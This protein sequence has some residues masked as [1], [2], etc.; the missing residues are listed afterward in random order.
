MR[1]LRPRE[2]RQHV[3]VGEKNHGKS[4][5]CSRTHSDVITGAPDGTRKVG[6]PVFRF[7]FGR[8]IFREPRG[9]STTLSPCVLTLNCVPGCKPSF[10][11]TRRRG[12]TWPLLERVVVMSYL[13]YGIS[14]ASSIPAGIQ[15]AQLPA[16]AGQ[17]SLF[18]FAK[19]KD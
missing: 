11:R 13:S 2:S 10:V 5:N 19:G 3:Y 1:V 12:T 16:R 15:G 17:K 14:R 6:R 9:M 7:R 8:T 18:G 4:A